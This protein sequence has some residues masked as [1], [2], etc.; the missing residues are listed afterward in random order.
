MT[1]SVG[2]PIFHALSPHKGTSGSHVKQRSDE[3]L[4]YLMKIMRSDQLL[5]GMRNYLS[6][7][8]YR[9]VLYSFLTFFNVVD[10][11]S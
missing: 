4:E 2:K 1:L 9:L 8:C 7:S 3:L 11:F 5:H 6:A 10:I